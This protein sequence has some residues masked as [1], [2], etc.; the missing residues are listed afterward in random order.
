M[1]ILDTH[2]GIMRKEIID[3]PVV[4]NKIIENPVSIVNEIDE[5]NQRIQEIRLPDVERR[6]TDDQGMQALN[7]KHNKVGDPDFFGPLK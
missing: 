2:R 6:N 7:K 1:G 5:I 3:I 4:P